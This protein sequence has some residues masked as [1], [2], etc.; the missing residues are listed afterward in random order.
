MRVPTA[1]LCLHTPHS[2]HTV[3]AHLKYS[4]HLHTSHVHTKLAHEH[5]RYECFS[6]HIPVCAFWGDGPRAPANASPISRDMEGLVI[7]LWLVSE[8]IFCVYMCEFMQLC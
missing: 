4:N 6:S 1:T 3:C 2:I 7:P 8:S 5:S